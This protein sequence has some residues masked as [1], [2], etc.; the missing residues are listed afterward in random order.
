MQN[1]AG[2][3]VLALAGV[4]LLAVGPIAQSQQRPV[5][6]A[7]ADLIV[8]DVQVVDR[9]GAPIADLKAGDFEVRVDRSVRKVVSAQFL[10]HEASSSP[11]QA[12]EPEAAAPAETARGVAPAG[13]S[14]ILA[15]DESS[16][17]ARNALAAMQAARRFIENLEPDDRIGLFKYPVY[18]KSVQLTTDHESVLEELQSVI[19]VLEVPQ[20]RYNLS[21]SEVID[22]T[23]EDS[24]ILDGSSPASAALGTR[25]FAVTRFSQRR[26]SSA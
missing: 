4:S 22:I 17:R 11:A 13:R 5:F 10:R 6:R 16:F 14:F 20:G 26:V 21:L 19:G 7:G 18:P 2:R 12:T 25:V 24:E 23:A 3:L 15:V 8:V 9:R 1:A